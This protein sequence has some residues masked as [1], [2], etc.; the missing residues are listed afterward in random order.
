MSF[1]R[2]SRAPVIM[3]GT[4]RDRGNTDHDQKAEAFPEIGFLQNFLDEFHRCQPLTAFCTASAASC[5]ETV[6]PVSRPTISITA[7][8][9]T[10]AMWRRASACNAAMRSLGLC[11]HGVGFLL[12]RGLGAFGFLREFG[13]RFFGSAA[14]AFARFDQR[15]FI[16]GQRVFRA[17]A[18][19]FGRRQFRIDLAAP[20]RNRALDARTGIPPQHDEQKRKRHRQP[21]NLAGKRLRLERREAALL[22]NRRSARRLGSIGHIRCTSG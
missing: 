12:G 2:L 19:L 7:S 16:G 4:R 3:P 18:A 14:C 22:G 15:R 10:S 17:A 6:S 20:F 9:A 13:A 21:E 5:A 1:A 11:R 8:F